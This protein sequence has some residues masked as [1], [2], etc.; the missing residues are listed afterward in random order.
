MVVSLLARAKQYHRVHQGLT[1]DTFHQGSRFE[2]FTSIQ[3]DT[4][5]LKS[6]I[7]DLAIWVVGISI[8]GIQTR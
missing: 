1:G 6:S 3:V 2:F 7:P 8:S 5:V 4:R